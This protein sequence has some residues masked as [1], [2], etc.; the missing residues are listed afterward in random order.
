MSIRLPCA[1]LISSLVAGCATSTP[2]PVVRLWPRGRS[3]TWVAG[4]EA[5]IRVKGGVRVAA[6]FE[7]QEERY[8]ALRVEI[9]NGG[10]R[11]LDVDPAEMMVTTCTSKDPGSCGAT[12]WV[13]DPERKLYAID[14]RRSRERARA[15]NDHTSRAPLIFLAGVGDLANAAD[16][17]LSTN[18]EAQEIAGNQDE[19][20]HQHVVERLE[21]EKERWLS[22]ALRHTTLLPGQ[23]TSGIVY[24]PIDRS[25]RFVWFQVDFGNLEFP[26]CFEQTVMGV[27]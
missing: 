25:A 2:A 1:L 19:A 20:R 21:D 9:E 11:T 10:T 15:R 27:S 13:I 14:A 22:I 5:V 8:L 18:V 4:R 26:F 23:S 16:G 24:V 6:A 3:A 17:H 12:D 7:Q